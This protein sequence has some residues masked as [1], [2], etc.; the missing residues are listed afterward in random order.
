MNGKNPVDGL[1]LGM[2]A[3]AEMAHSFYVTMLEAGASSQEAQAAENAFI[4][5]FWHESTE[6]ARRKKREGK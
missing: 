5:A 2:G 1:I 3:L 6:D 4:T